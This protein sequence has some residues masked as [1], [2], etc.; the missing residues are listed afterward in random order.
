MIAMNIADNNSMPQ[1]QRAYIAA[2]V[3]CVIVAATA[4]AII[5][6]PDLAF[7]NESAFTHSTN[8]SEAWLNLLGTCILVALVEEII[9]RG[10]LLRA[11]FR[12]LTPKAVILI[13]AG[14]FAILHAIPIGIDTMQ[15]IDMVMVI[16]SLSLKALQAFA[17][18]ILM[19]AII[20]FGFNL[21]GVIVIHAVFDAI[22]FAGTVLTIGAFPETYIATSPTALTALAVST[23]I[24]AVP[25]ALAF[26]FP[27]DSLSLE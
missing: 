6:L 8:S 18:G 14:I 26:L 24:L 21:I 7:S 9:F 22:Y 19:A 3:I 5:S 13:T 4:S 11:L 1:I 2:V 12:I 20:F 23:I 25:A 17:F 16:A 27:K 10:I 15:G